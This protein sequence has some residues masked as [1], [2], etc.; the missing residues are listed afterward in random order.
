MKCSHCNQIIPDESVFCPR[1]GNKVETPV[2]ENKASDAM[3][4]EIAK[5]PKKKKRKLIAAVISISLLLVVALGILFG[6][7][8][9]KYKVCRWYDA[10]GTLLLENRIKDGENPIDNPLPEDSDKWDY[11]KW[12]K[13]EESPDNISF[14]AQ[15]EPQNS[16]F[17]GNVFQIIVEDLGQTPVATGSAF[18]FN[19]D[20]WFIT[21]AHVVEGAYYLKGIFNI[22]NNVTKESFTYLE[23]ESGSYYH[24]KKDIYIGKLKNYQSISNYYKDFSFTQSYDMG[25]ITYSVGYPNSSA[26]LKINK[27]EVT[28]IWSDLYEKLYSGHSYICSSSEIAPGS[29]GGILV[30]ENLEILGMTTL[31]WFDKNEK[32]ISGAAISTYNYEQLLKDNAVE[33]LLIPHIERFHSD[34]KIY[35]G[36]YNMFRESGTG[37]VIMDDGDVLYYY[38]WLREGTTDNGNAFTREETLSAASDGYMSYS[39][40][41][42]WDSGAR[43]KISFYGYYSNARGL[44][45]FVFEYKYTFPDGKVNE[46]RCDD[47]NYSPNLSLTLNKAYVVDAPY[48]YKVSEDEYMKERFNDIYEWL[49]DDME[50]FKSYEWKINVVA[51]NSSEEDKTT[52]MES[53]KINSPIYFHINLTGGKQNEEVAIV[54][55]HTLSNG[56]ISEYTFDEKWADGWSGWYGW[57]NGLSSTGTLICNFYDGDGNMIGVGSVK[58]IE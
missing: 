33:V 44:D 18:V 14:T 26:D 19:K 49:R 15:R 11:I 12:N 21:N 48:S 55:K 25:Q 2:P 9:S 28:D 8:N 34:E 56:T 31:G 17:V 24:L 23:I 36:Y 5:E 16:Y 35:I 22:S 50:R 30:N 37:P 13:N 46:I 3:P 7:L 52:N 39:D 1:C 38:E 27:G 45:D 42:Y 57:S 47:I 43:L 54:V 4:N 58:I 32:F 51:I 20:G 29:S 53:I 6:V 40:M 41:V 10:D